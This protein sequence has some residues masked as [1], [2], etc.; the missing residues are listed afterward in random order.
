MCTQ[1]NKMTRSNLFTFS[2]MARSCFKEHQAKDLNITDSDKIKRL[3]VSKNVKL[4]TSIQQTHTRSKYYKFNM[5][6]FSH[7]V[8]YRES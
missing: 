4:M 1:Y 6:I 5:L 2:K 3:Q 7:P 8:G